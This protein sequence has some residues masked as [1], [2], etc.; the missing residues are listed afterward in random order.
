[1]SDIDVRLTT[2]QMQL[3]VDLMSEVQTVLHNFMSNS[4]GSKPIISSFILELAQ[5][6]YHRRL[7]T[8]EP[9]GPEQTHLDS[10]IDT[11]DISS[12]ETPH[13]SR[14]RG[15]LLFRRVSS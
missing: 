9:T 3:A 5:R 8:A 13:S 14:M 12:V 15:S 4:T 10:G 11:A 1:M 2:N 7:T 6:Q